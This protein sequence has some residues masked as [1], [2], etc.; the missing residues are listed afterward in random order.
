[1]WIEVIQDG[2]TG[3]EKFCKMIMNFVYGKDLLNS[4]LFSKIVFKKKNK[5]LIDQCLPKFKAAKQITPDFYVIEREIATSIP[6]TL[7]YRKSFSL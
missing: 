5:T 1:M 3:M 4:E 6:S 7:L 2:N